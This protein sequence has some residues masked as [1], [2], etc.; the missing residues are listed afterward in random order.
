[1]LLAMTNITGS[2]NSE[3]DVPEQWLNRETRL[4]LRQAER[5]FEERDDDRQSLDELRD[6]LAAQIAHR[7]YRRSAQASGKVLPLRLPR[8]GDEEPVLSED[9]LF[10]VYLVM[11]SCHK[12][13]SDQKITG[14]HSGLQW[15]VALRGYA[16]F[17]DAF[18]C[19]QGA[20]MNPG[21]RCIS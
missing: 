17:S 5:C 19:P 7:H 3:D 9:Q 4:R 13:S 21:K 11:Q 14:P 6:L 12:Q 18:Q 16:N 1:M 8:G 10:F 15:N 20:A 2:V